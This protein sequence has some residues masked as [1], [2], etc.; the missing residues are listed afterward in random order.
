[1]YSN[2]EDKTDGM[3]VY[4]DDGHTEYWNNT[5]LFNELN[6]RGLQFL[7]TQMNL[8]KKSVFDNI[9]NKNRGNYLPELLKSI[10]K[11]DILEKCVILT[12]EE[13]VEIKK[14]HLS[15]LPPY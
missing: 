4:F 11:K 5:R 14:R 12:L 6:Y 15:T 3:W 2:D 9:D 13:Y 7:K 1:M 8:A 10:H